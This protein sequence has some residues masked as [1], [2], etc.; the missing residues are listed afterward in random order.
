MCSYIGLKTLSLVVKLRSY[1][2]VKVKIKRAK[3]CKL[4]Y[5]AH[6]AAHAAG[7][8]IRTITKHPCKFR[9]LREQLVYG[10]ATE[11]RL[12]G[13]LVQTR[14]SCANKGFLCRQSWLSCADN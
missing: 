13:F 11:T 12:P 14:L 4:N 1:V 3:S 9:E 6:A 2:Q 7:T 8:I 5:I 10:S